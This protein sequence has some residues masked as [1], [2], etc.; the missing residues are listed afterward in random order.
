MYIKCSCDYI[1]LANRIRALKSH[2]GMA[3][4]DGIKVKELLVKVKPHEAIAAL[5]LYTGGMFV[6]PLSQSAGPSGEQN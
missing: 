1:A 6:V 4:Q 3:G 5:E 2:S